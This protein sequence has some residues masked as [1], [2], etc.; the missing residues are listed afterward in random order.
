V[1]ALRIEE[2]EQIL[3]LHPFLPKPQYI[4]VVE[5]PVIAQLDG[6]VAIVRGAT[7]AW[8]R[9]MIVVTPVA[10]HDTVVHEIIHTMGLGEV[11]AT[12]GGAILARFREAF[13]PIVKYDVKYEV[14]SEPHSK[15]KIYRRVK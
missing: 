3:K 11:A 7:P 1:G 5:E 15:V 4:V 9:D 12:V 10:G 6:L 13:K 2:L 14:A 8:R